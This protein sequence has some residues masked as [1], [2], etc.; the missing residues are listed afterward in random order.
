MFQK[1]NSPSFS[2]VSPN[3]T[4]E[5]ASSLS[6]NTHRHQPAQE[7]CGKMLTVF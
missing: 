7:W 2:S 5:L 4:E 3:H 6:S 1:L